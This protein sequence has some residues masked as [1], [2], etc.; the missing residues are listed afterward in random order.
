M[1][2]QIVSNP[3]DA[4]KVISAGPQS[5]FDKPIDQQIRDGVAKEAS[6]QVTPLPPGAGI[7]SPLPTPFVPVAKHVINTLL[8]IPNPPNV[9]GFRVWLVAEVR[10]GAVGQEDHYQLRP[11]DQ[12]LGNGADGKTASESLVPCYLLDTHAGVEVC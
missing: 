5:P 3:G 9:G 10:L 4:A 1:L 11:I 6:L 2:K 8:R 12:K 7:N